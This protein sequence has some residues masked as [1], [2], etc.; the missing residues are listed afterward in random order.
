MAISEIIYLSYE[1]VIFLHIDQ[2]Y[3]AGELRFGVF[4][5]DLIDSALNRPQHAAAYENADL[6]RQAA[7]LYFGFIK[8]HPWFGGNKRTASTIVDAFLMVNSFAI[9]A[10]KEDILELVLAIESDHFNVDD[11]EKWLRPR[12]VKFG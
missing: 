7:T 4:D 8:N 3:L 2:M 10:K 6:I 9:A 1:E 5:R 12:V 11:I